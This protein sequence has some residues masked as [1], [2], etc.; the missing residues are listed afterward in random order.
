[1]ELFR[2]LDRERI[3]LALRGDRMKDHRFFQFPASAK[4][5]DDLTHVMSVDRAEIQDPEFLKRQVRSEKTLGT[6]LDVFHV[7]A[8]ELAEAARFK[9]TG[10]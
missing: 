9:H 1:M 7:P 10:Q 2:I 3:P 8:Q 6:V 5:F 4:I